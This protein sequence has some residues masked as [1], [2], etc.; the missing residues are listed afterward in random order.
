MTESSRVGDPATRLDQLAISVH[1]QARDIEAEWRALFESAGSNVYQ[2]FEWTDCWLTTAAP[3]LGVRPAVVAL[4]WEGQLVMLIPLGIERIGPLRVARY[5]GG[6]HA[7]IRMPLAAAD[8]RSPI[9]DAATDRL[10][11]RVAAALGGVDLFDFDALPAD[12]PETTHFLASHRAARP[13]R[14]N[15]GTLPLEADFAAL[16][17]AH[18]GAKKSKKHRWQKNA[19]AP[20]GGYR[21]RRAQT[22]AEAAA[23]FDT[24]L[25]EKAAWFRR[26]GIADSFAEPGIAP[27]FRALIA[28]RWAGDENTVID[29]DAIEFDGGLHAILGSGTAMGRQSGYFLAVADDEWRRISPGELLIHDVIAAACARGT[30]LIDLGRGEERYKASWLDRTETHVR[31]LRPVTLVGRI[32]A[33]AL[34]ARDAAERRVRNDERL[35]RLVMRLRRS[36]AEG[37]AASDS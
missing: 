5:L 17:A 6:E 30:R 7:N 26:M 28:R 15:V 36:R 23:M 33:L 8:W 11:A 9:D 27:F 19:L 21:L 20:V 34:R 37:Q 14:C 12:Q 31:L 25:G 22:G 2:S 29:I 1:A 32:G 10:L 3:A 16:L 24:F 18:R 35:W 13:A 4:R